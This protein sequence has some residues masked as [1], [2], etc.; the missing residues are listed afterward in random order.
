MA[1]LGRSRCPDTALNVHVALRAGAGQLC[2]GNTFLIGAIPVVPLV[3]GA[4]RSVLLFIMSISPYLCEGCWTELKGAGRLTLA[5]L[6]RQVDL[7]LVYITFTGLSEARTG[8]QGGN[9]CLQEINWIAR[10]LLALLALW[11]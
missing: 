2:Q 4:K 9:S 7:V 8:S 3:L 10:C 6:L 1:L 11:L 5:N